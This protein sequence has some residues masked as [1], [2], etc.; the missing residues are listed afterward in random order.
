MDKRTKEGKD[1]SKDVQ[2]NRKA[3]R[4]ANYF[5]LKH[6]GRNSKIVYKNMRKS[7]DDK[8]NFLK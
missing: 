2:S 5:S 6:V 3:W 7:Y 1:C 4:R 8:I